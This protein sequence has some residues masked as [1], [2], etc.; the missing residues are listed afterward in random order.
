MN[1]PETEKEVEGE[2]EAHHH[3]KGEEIDQKE[4]KMVNHGKE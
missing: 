4:D 2:T 1:V 3:V